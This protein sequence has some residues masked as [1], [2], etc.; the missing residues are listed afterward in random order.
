MPCLLPPPPMALGHIDFT[1]A[2]MKTWLAEVEAAKAAIDIAGTPMILLGANSAL[3]QP[4]V[5]R[6]LALESVLALVDNA[7]AGRSDHGV[8]VLDDAGLRDLLAEKPLA[9]GVLCCSSKEAIAHFTA[10]WAGHGPLLSF[11]EAI[12]LW[13]E[14][15]RAGQPFAFLKAFADTSLVLNLHHEGRSAFGDTLSRQTFDA[16]MLYR[17]TWDA[18]YL[19][20]VNRPEKAIYFE[21]DVMPLSQ[22]EVLV[23]GGAFDGDTVR[24]FVAKTGGRYDHIHAFELDP[25]NAA[26]FVAKTAGID[27]LS[28]YQT[29][30]WDGPASLRLEQRSDNCSRISDTGGLSVPLQ[31]LDN[32]NLGRISLFKLDIEGAEIEAL[33]GA[34]RLIVTHKPK[35]ALSAYHKCDDFATLLAKVRSM[36]QDYVFSLRHYSQVI[37]DSVIYAI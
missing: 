10:I 13:P 25:H 22:H 15:A 2:D 37:F 29:G 35:L 11:F 33:E 8:P 14:T 6:A 34:R 27:S 21:P 23:D 36:R 26:A 9:I 32:M 4:F 19:E 7:R 5:A 20:K 17:L 24:D 16:I 18:G 31:A 3:A 30:L 28:L 1:Q 12:C